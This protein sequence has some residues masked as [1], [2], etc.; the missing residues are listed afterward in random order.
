[1]DLLIAPV[2][3][4]DPSVESR[5]GIFCAETYGST[6]SDPADQPA[7]P[8]LDLEERRVALAALGQESLLA[9]DERQAGIVIETLPCPLLIVTGTADRQ[10]PRTRYAHLHLPATRMEAA[11]ASHW[12]LVLNRLVTRDARP[13]RGRVDRARANS[14]EERRISA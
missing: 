7:M 3:R 14:L 8:D 4:P 9:R 11:G 6:S 13:R 1:M 5:R 12:G 10:W 2:R